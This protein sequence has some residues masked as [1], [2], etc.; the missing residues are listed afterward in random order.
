MCAQVYTK[1]A[2]VFV[3]ECWED[4]RVIH[5]WTTGELQRR[6]WDSSKELS[7]TRLCIDELIIWRWLTTLIQTSL[8]MLIHGNQLQDTFVR[9]P[10]ELFLGGVQSRHWLLLPLWRLSLYLVL[11]LPCMVYGWRVSLLGLKLWIQFLGHWGYI[12]TIQLL[13]LW[14][15]TI[16]VVVEINTSTLS[17]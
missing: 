11:R 13:S 1:P 16:R 15:R 3:V 8:A 17:I 9:L 4:I 5:V 6:C 12:V 14:L 2:I 10:V 7:I